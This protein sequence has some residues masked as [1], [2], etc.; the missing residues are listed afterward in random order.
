MCLG[1]LLLFFWSCVLFVMTCLEWPDI[2]LF[3]FDQLAQSK[4]LIKHSSPWH[5]IGR[6]HHTRNQLHLAGV[7][8]AQLLFHSCPLIF[9]ISAGLLPYVFD[10]CKNTQQLTFYTE[11]APFAR[12]HWLI[13]RTNTGR[14]AHFSYW[15]NS[16]P[17]TFPHFAVHSYSLSQWS[18]FL[19]P[20]YFDIWQRRRYLTRWR[21]KDTSLP[22]QD[23]SLQ[24]G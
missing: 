15:N 19:S 1:P 7:I 14:N 17:A 16:A 9:P 18:E 4:I 10:L 8:Y 24:F 11:I 6:N 5:C 20:L 3:F 23:I 12:I 21:Y 2:Q 22:F 13:Q